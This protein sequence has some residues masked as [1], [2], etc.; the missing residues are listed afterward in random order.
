MEAPYI[1]GTDYLRK[2]YFKDPKWYQ[3][4][5]G[6]ASL[7]MEEIKVVYLARFLRGLTLL[8]WDF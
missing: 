6:I 8:L 4:A 7:E 2:G 1:L 5:F 3:Q